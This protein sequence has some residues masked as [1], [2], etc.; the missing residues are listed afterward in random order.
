MNP[1]YRETI[2]QLKT[3]DAHFARLFHRHNDLDQEIRNREAGIIPTTH[4]SLEQLKKQK[5]LLK[6]QLYAI[7]R[8]SGA[9]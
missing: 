3:T 9:A 5:L 6:D 8:K 7:L 2:S 1:E 4:T